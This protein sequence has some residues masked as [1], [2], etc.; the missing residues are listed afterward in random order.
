[1]ALEL[2]VTKGQNILKNVINGFITDGRNTHK[3]GI[4]ISDYAR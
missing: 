3:N 2:L 4:S 1:M